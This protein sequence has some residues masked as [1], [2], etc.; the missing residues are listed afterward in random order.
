M[1]RETLEQWS[2]TIWKEAYQVDSTRTLEIT[3]ELLGAEVF[4]WTN[5][6]VSQLKKLAL[7]LFATARLS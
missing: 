7:A 6:T 2:K 5:L 1:T 3:K 4:C